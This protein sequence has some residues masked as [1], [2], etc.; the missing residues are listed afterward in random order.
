M[1]RVHIVFDAAGEVVYEAVWGRDRDAERVAFERFVDRATGEL[2]GAAGGTIVVLMG[3]AQR[4]TIATALIAGGLPADTPV[5]LVERGNYDIRLEAAIV[6]FLPAAVLRRRAWIIRS[7]FTD[8][9]GDRRTATNSS[10]RR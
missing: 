9:A 8:I 6:A 5:A 10:L 7:L 1:S 4:A 2:V 3:V